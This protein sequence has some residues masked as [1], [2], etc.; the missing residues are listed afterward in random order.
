MDRQG[1][2]FQQSLSLSLLLSSR[3]FSTYLYHYDLLRE[4]SFVV[5]IVQTVDIGSVGPI[6][7]QS[8]GTTV[9][10]RFRFRQM[11]QCTVYSVV[12][13]VQCSLQCTVYGVQ[14]TVQ[15]TVY[16]VLCQMHLILLKYRVH[17]PHFMGPI[18]SRRNYNIVLIQNLN[19]LKKSSCKNCRTSSPP[20][21][22][23]NFK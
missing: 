10:I 6:Q 13:S 21:C 9:R 3:L 18:V 14:C 7:L 1:Y 23:M 15:C 5:S 19:L 11:F 8:S 17:I 12:Y 4:T 20:K 16:S 22:F 2:I